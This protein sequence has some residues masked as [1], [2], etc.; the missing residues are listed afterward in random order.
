[1]SPNAVAAICATLFAAHLYIAFGHRVRLGS[2]PADRSRDRIASARRF[3]LAFLFLT[4]GL[5]LGGARRVLLAHGASY[6][7]ALDLLAFPANDA[8]LLLGT[9]VFVLG[10]FVR[11]WAIR[12]L[13]RF[14]TF[15]IG[16]RRDHAVI[17]QGPYRWVRHP[18]YTGYVLLLLGLNLAYASGLMFLGTVPPTLVFLALRIRDE[19]KMLVQHFGPAYSDYMRRTKRLIPAIY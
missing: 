10:L 9:G 6:P 13:G 7:E 17:E 1:M 19:E 2:D 16:I 8:T 15:E 4:A 11:L 14:F 12:V 18:S 3:T 5:A